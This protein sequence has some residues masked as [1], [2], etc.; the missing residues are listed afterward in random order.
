[1]SG[2]HV[3]GCH[4]KPRPT[5]QSSYL[6]QSG[7][8][9]SGQTNTRYPRMVPIKSAFGTTACQYDRSQFDQACFGCPHQKGALA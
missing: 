9:E 8:Y 3:Y 5:V 6:A 4:S 2:G 7:W 1:M